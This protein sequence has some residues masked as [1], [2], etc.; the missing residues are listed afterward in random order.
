MN[1]KDLF[2]GHSK[3]YSTFRPTYPESMYAIIF[4]NVRN[5]DS[6]WDCATGNGQ[7][8]Q[9][10]AKDF[11]KVFATDISPQQIAEATAV[12]NITY[13]VS[14]AESTNFPD[15]R[16]DLITVGQAIHW[17]DTQKFYSEVIRTSKPNGV[18]AI[19]GYSLLSVNPEIDELILDF[20]KNTVGTYWDAARKLVDEKYR[21]VPFPFRQ[22]VTPEL[23][24]EVD[25]TLEH[26]AGYL[27]SWS[28]A[29]KYIQHRGSD[30]VPTLI[31]LIKPYWR[32]GEVKS[33]WFPLF[34]KVG[35]VSK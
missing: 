22:I 5:K 2:S 35:T 13:S 21:D 8:A 3:I 16:F 20:Y 19:W 30:P 33:A 17:I 31:N 12:E 11:K 34:L 28:A 25:W 18:I 1:A 10:L 29:Q 23:K 26:L 7:A 4:A 14:S 9:R 15:N 32:P 6:A 24:L 27:T